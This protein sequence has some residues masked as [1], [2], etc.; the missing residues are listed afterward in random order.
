MTWEATMDGLRGAA[1]DQSVPDIGRKF[2]VGILGVMHRRKL[3]V[4]EEIAAAI[5]ARGGA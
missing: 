4:L 3:K 5:R 1:N 2:L